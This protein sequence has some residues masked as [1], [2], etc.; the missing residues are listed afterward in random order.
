MA[1]NKGDKQPEIIH[2]IENNL[3]GFVV[4]P[5]VADFRLIASFCNI[6]K[7]IKNRIVSTINEVIQ[8][9]GGMTIGSADMMLCAHKESRASLFLILG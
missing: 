7:L 4:K 9:N 1:P 5:I 3:S 8:R 2:K 6:L